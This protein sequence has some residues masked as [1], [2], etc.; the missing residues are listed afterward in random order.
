MAAAAPSAAAA[1]RR[2]GRSSA[3]RRDRS[4]AASSSPSRARSSPPTTRIRRSR[5]ATSS[6]RRA[7]SCSP[8]R[9]STTRAS[10]GRSR[11]GRRSSTSSPRRP[12]PRTGRSSTTIPGSPRS[13]ATSPRSASCPT[14]GSGR[15]GG[16]RPARRGPDDRRAAGDPVDVRLV[17]VADQ[18]ARLVRARARPR[19]LP[20]GA[21]RGRAGRDRPA[22]ARVAVPVEPLRQ[23]RDEPGQGRHG[24]RPA[25]RRPRHRAPATTV[26]GTR[27]RPNTAGPS[28]CSG[29][30]PGA[31]AC[32]T[33]RRSSSARWRCATRTSTRCRSSRSGC[34]P[35]CAA[36]APDDPERDRVL[37]LVQLTV[38]GVAAGLQSTGLA[39]WTTPTTS[40]C[41]GTA[42]VP[43][44]TL[45]RHRRRDRGLHAGAG[46][47]ARAGRTDRGGRPGR[48]GRSTQNARPSAARFPAVELET[49]AADF[50]RSARPAA[51]DG[52]VAANSLH[53]VPRDRQV[54]GHPD[55]GRAS[56]AGRAVRGRRVRRRPRQSVGAASVQLRVVGADSP[57]PPVSSR[58]GG[59]GASRAAS[60]ARST[61]PS[62]AALTGIADRVAL[63]RA[64]RTRFGS[65]G[66]G[67]PRYAAAHRNADPPRTCGTVGFRPAHDAAAVRFLRRPRLS[68]VDPAHNADMTDVGACRASGRLRRRSDLPVVA[69]GGRHSGLAVVGLRPRN[70]PYWCVWAWATPA[71]SKVRAGAEASAP[72]R[73]PPGSRS[74]RYD[75]RAGG[76][77]RPPTC[78]SRPVRC[79]AAPRSGSGPVRDPARSSRL[80]PASRRPG[81]GSGP[82][83]RARGPKRRRGG[84]VAEPGNGQRGHRP[85]H[86]VG[87]R[88]RDPE[89][90]A[91]RS[92]PSSAS[93]WFAAMT[94]GQPPPSACAA[95][96]SSRS[97]PGAPG[98]PSDPRVPPSRTRPGSG[99]R[100]IERLVRA[101][102]HDQRMD[103][104]APVRAGPR[105]PPSPSARTATCGRCRSSRPRRARRGR[106]GP[107]PALG[108]VDERV[109]APAVEL[110]DELARPAGPAPSGS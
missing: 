109:D 48:G 35:G 67:W 75:A 60:S 31:S 68:P 41:C 82:R 61:R 96:P 58:R 24:R 81:P 2:T 103:P 70:R 14:C 69:C 76:P 94:A 30:S 6:R 13:S 84:V 56:A 3:R 59:S 34:W 78:R 101:V 105:A 52:L 99:V 108:A 26:A 50:T 80:E 83:A 77:A 104:V 98:T 12:A 11:S 23:R 43:G 42:V 91:I 86:R 95:P 44:G 87:R 110:R 62:P 49:L 71:S 72:A 39:A 9:P 63:Q 18:P 22:R 33:G 8:R 100:S 65:T 88:R 16:P 89:R 21:R 92:R 106:A 66:R 5:G 27:S 57:R 38:N 54:G 102:R 55:A 32:S 29:G 73:G 25:L 51:L 40:R 37:R 28:P 19:G 10:S 15:A 93:A 53:F 85:E 45:G 36:L 46:G 97:P 17:A 90:R 74:A 20:S 7:R 79:S 107:C 64:T 4:T 1:A 47:P